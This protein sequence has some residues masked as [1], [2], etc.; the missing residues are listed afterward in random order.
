MACASFS[1]RGGGVEPAGGRWS[2]HVFAGRWQL[3]SGV[4]HHHG[5]AEKGLGVSKSKFVLSSIYREEG[6]VPVMLLS[7]RA[8]LGPGMYV[9]WRYVL[10]SRREGC[11]PGNENTTPEFSAVIFSNGPM[12]MADFEML[13]WRRPGLTSR[14]SPKGQLGKDRIRAR[15]RHNVWPS[16]R[17]SCRCG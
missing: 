5:M 7:M 13:R 15:L 12:E 2:C 6:S 3:F 17:L 10:S 11:N 14:P 16:L 8:H 9:L 1:C 4:G